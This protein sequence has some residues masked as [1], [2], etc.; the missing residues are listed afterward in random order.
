M[1]SLLWLLLAC[2]PKV[3][4]GAVVEPMSTTGT[5]S[6]RQQVRFDLAT[7]LLDAGRVAEAQQLLAAA[8]KDGARGAE[9]TMLQGRALLAQGLWAEAR[10]QLTAAA[11]L[12]RK[13]ARAPRWLALLEVDAGRP[14][15]A[16]TSFAE[17]VRL[18]PNDAKT[19][20]NYGFVLFSLQRH[21]EAERALS[22]AVK[23]DG[24]NP[25]YRMNLAYNQAAL[26]RDADALQSFRSAGSESD[27]HENLAIACE[28]RGDVDAAR[29]H[30]VLAIAAN[31]SQKKSL[32]ALE[33]LKAASPAAEEQP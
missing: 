25:K 6:G 15:V 14:L 11:A 27:A 9:F 24:T 16:I 4:K 1:L 21:D 5:K 29:R 3:P 7:A 2:G 17:A 19:W 18:D 8:A 22:M 32:E 23:L 10:E 28:L 12:D 33:R 20:N 13:D 30:Y 26:R 31:P